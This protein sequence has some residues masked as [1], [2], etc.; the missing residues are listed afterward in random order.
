MSVGTDT[1][2]SGSS[3]QNADAKKKKKEKQS[4][5]KVTRVFYTACFLFLLPIVKLVGK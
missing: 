2:T 3:T 1:L 5:V 4:Y